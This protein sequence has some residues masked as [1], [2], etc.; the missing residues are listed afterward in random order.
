MM[1]KT[2]IGAVEYAALQWH[3]LPRDQG[4]IVHRE[5][6]TDE[7]GNLYCRT[8]DQSDRSQS[9]TVADATDSDEP[10]EPWNGTLPDCGEHETCY[11]APYSI[12]LRDDGARETRTVDDVPDASDCESEAEDWA[13][14]GEWGDDGARVEVGYTVTDALGQ[15]MD[16]DGFASVDIEPRHSALIASAVGRY[17]LDRICGT[18]PDDH[19][20][21]SEGE[22]G[23]TEN[24]GVWSVGGT[25]MTF[26]S[27]CRRC[28]LHRHEHH[29][30]SQRN[31]GDHDT[32]TY[33]MLDDYEIEFH[34]HNGSM[35]ERDAE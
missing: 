5:Y 18:D 27:H 30:G 26:D 19:D 21:T 14:D 7:A 34:V 10:F 29:T 2:S 23:C 8:T 24:P 4:Q 28:G 32:V 11:V 1:T 33:R 17:D 22:G 31:P 20:W 16:I 25:A 12:H 35:D 6:A 13:R 9:L 3:T 15:D